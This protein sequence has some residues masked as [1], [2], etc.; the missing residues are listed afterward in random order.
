MATTPGVVNNL[1]SIARYSDVTNT[2]KNS[3]INKAMD[4]QAFLKLFTTQLQNQNPLDPMKN[5]NFV[6]Q[7]AQ[8]SQLEAT[9]N[10]S[11]TL[12]DYVNSQSGER[13]LSSAALIGKKVAVTGADAVLSSGQPVSASI[14]LDQGADGLTVKVLNSKGET[15]RTANYG[16]QAAGTLSLNWDGRDDAGN[17]MPDGNYQ[18]QAQ[19]VVQGKNT[20]PD[21]AVFATVQSISQSGS[22]GSLQVQ[23]AGGKSVPLSSVQRITN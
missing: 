2:A 12:K 6:A 8:F 4:Q 21:V 23:V 22:D 15:V 1:S 19:G 3:P 14:Q 16:I 17:P 11:T 5:E 13:M 9:T 7:L 20:K 10:M 18:F